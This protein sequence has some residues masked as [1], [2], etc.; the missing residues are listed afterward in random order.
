MARLDIHRIWIQR[1]KLLAPWFSLFLGIV[2]GFVMSR[3]YEQSFRF[4]ASLFAF[5]LFLGLTRASFSFQ[6]PKP[7]VDFASITAT[8]FFVQY[9]LMF[10]LPFAYFKGTWG[11]GLIL[12]GLTTCTLWDPFWAKILRYSAFR[13]ILQYF[14]YGLSI[15]FL[16]PICFPTG[17][18]FMELTFIAGSAFV[19]FPWTHLLQKKQVRWHQLLWFI[20]GLSYSVTLPFLPS[21]LH[22]PV[23]SLWIKDTSWAVQEAPPRVCVQTRI[24]APEGVTEPVEAIWT[25]DGQTLDKILLPPIQGHSTGRGFMTK[26]CKSVFKQ[27][28]Y[29]QSDIHKLSVCF[30]LR[31]KIF[32]S[33]DKFSTPPERR[34][35]ASESFPDTIHALWGGLASQSSN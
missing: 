30:Y 20:M 1:F 15:Y 34:P 8:Q 26:T 5:V 13:F 32:I 6:K 24:V 35:L 22:F 19:L 17:L 29:H 7:L 23:L 12:L 16:Y 9:I 2:S 31:Q 18:D 3:G 11:W 10:L 25:W 14:T 33:C 28:K 21:I 4:G 27:E